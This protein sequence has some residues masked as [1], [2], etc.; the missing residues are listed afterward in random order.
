MGGLTSYSEFE[1]FSCSQPLPLNSCLQW[2]LVLPTSLPA[3]GFL[4]H[5]VVFCGFSLCSRKLQL[6]SLLSQ[7]LLIFLLSIFQ[8]SVD[9]LHL[10][11]FSFPLLFVFMHVY[12]YYCLIAILVNLQEDAKK[13]VFILPCLSTPPK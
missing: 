6:P 5:W 9:I 13:Y 7:L 3:L 4:K 11:P 1:Q 12:F 2:F 8:I 10:L